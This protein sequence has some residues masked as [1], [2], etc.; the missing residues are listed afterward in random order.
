MELSMSPF[1]PQRVLT[2][3]NKHGKILFIV[4]AFNDNAVKST[5]F[6]KKSSL[7]GMTYNLTKKNKK[8][9]FYFIN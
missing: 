1:L 5:W 7:N 4:K 8:K 9:V 3:A 2:K 6:K